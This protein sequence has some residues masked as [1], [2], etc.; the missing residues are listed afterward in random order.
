M[1][2]A[3]GAT[4]QLAVNWSDETFRKMSTRI[5]AWGSNGRLIADRQECQVY[6]READSPIAGVRKGWT[7]RYTTELT[8]AVWYY[9]RG[10]EYSAQIDYFVKSIQQGRIDGT[11]SFRS[12][13]EADRVAAGIRARQEDAMAVPPAPGGQAQTAARGLWARMLG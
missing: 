10:E 5:S 2:Y 11:N 7:V 3:G 4:G 9:L 6:L 1:Y 8:E 13:L 12:A